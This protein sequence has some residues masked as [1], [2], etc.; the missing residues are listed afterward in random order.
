MAFLVSIYVSKLD[1]WGAEGRTRCSIRRFMGQDQGG[2]N[3][4]KDLSWRILV[5]RVNTVD[6]YV[7][8][9]CQKWLL[10]WFPVLRWVYLTRVDCPPLA[11]TLRDALIWLSTNEWLFQKK[12]SRQ[13]HWSLGFG[14]RAKY[15]APVSKHFAFLIHT[16]ESVIH[17]P[18]GSLAKKFGSH[19]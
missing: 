18:L 14:S 15:L 2:C 1:V 4:V 16:F 3:G 5:W 13:G 11:S 17:W 12:K 19:V 9:W 7:I 8:I 10:H 6:Y